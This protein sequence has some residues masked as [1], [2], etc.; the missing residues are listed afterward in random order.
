MKLGTIVHAVLVGLALLGIWIFAYQL[1]S[2]VDPSRRI[3]YAFSTAV[4]VGV[5]YWACRGA[6]RFLTG[7]DKA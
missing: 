4:I 6:W 1:A 2:D 7:Q 3:G 5:G